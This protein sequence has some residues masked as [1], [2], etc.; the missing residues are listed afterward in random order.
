MVVAQG[1]VTG[2]TSV[3][4]G[5]FLLKGMEGPTVNHSGQK[6]LPGENWGS[7]Q[8]GREE[9]FSCLRGQGSFWLDLFS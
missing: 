5:S 1:T 6:L 7:S 3:E 2:H 4:G 8:R 9:N